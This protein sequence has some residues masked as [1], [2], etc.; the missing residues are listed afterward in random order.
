MLQVIIYLLFFE[1]CLLSDSFKIQ[2]EKQKGKMELFD[3]A[4]LCTGF[5]LFKSTL[6]RHQLTNQ[7]IHTESFQE[8][9]E[10]LEVQLQN[11]ASIDSPNAIEKSTPQNTKNKKKQENEEKLISQSSLRQSK[12]LKK[13]NI[14]QSTFKEV[15][16]AE[17]CTPKKFKKTPIRGKN[18]KLTE[19]EILKLFNSKS[20]IISVK[21]VE[22]FNISFE[23]SYKSSSLDLSPY[24]MKEDGLPDSE[25]L[26]DSV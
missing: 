4:R 25:L 23:N 7:T 26:A 20:D 6:R 8:T 5:H 9:P 10:L 2:T 21:S 14:G 15:K 11:L 1:T 3:L 24:E 19:N 13:N 17:K 12:R 18:K 16:P 22:D